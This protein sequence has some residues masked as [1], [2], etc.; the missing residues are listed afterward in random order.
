MNYCAVDEAFNNSLNKKISEYDRYA[1]L[2][3]DNDYPFYSAQGEN[4]TGTKIND[5]KNNIVESEEESFSFFDSDVDGSISSYSSDRSHDYY[6]DKMFNNLINDN[7]SL[8]SLKNS[9]DESVYKH[10]KSC[11]L[12]KKSLD[13][14]MKDYYQNMYSN[15][16]LVTNDNRIVETKPEY[17]LN[18]IITVLVVGIIFIF[19][20][21]FLVRIGRKF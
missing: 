4:I 9:V 16:D 11:K 6:V 3:C 2:G 15:N 13:N 14:K 12:C 8:E 18:E 17:N 7:D 19:V 10:I 20:L 21:D 1:E 5:L